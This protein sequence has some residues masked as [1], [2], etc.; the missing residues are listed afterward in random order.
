MQ[1]ISDAASRGHIQKWWKEQIVYQIYPRSFKDSNGDGVGDLRGIIDKL[2][3]IKSLGVTSVWINPIYASPND[4]NGY[5]ISDYRAIMP[6]FGTMADFDELL[7]GLHARGIKFIMDLVVNHSSDEHEWFKQSRSSR[8]NPYRDYYHWWP[9]EKGKPNWRWSY[10]DERGDAWKYDEQTDSYYLHY[11]AVKQPDLNWENPKVRQE[12]YDIM[13]FWAQKGVDGFRLD[14]FQF[15][16]K[17]TDFPQLPDEYMEGK[18]HI[19]KYHGMGPNIHAYLREMYEEVLS[20]YDVFAVSEGAGSS[21]QDAHDLVDTHRNELQIAY[22]FEGAELGKN[23][24]NPHTLL[25]FKQLY[26]AWDESFSSDGWLSIFLANHDMSRMVS[27]WGNDSDEHREASTK[28]LNT[29]LLTMRGTPFTYFGDELGMTNIRFQTIEEYKDID[30]INGYKKAQADGAD[31]DTFMRNLIEYSR[32]N[33]RTPMHW[34]ASTQAGFTTGEPWINVHENHAV[35]NVE[36]QEADPLSPLNH[37][38]ALTALRQQHK[39]LV[40][41]DYELLLAEHEDIYAY[42]RRYEGQSMLV[43]MNFSANTHTVSLAELLA[44]TQVL[45]NNTT[46]CVIEGEQITLTPYQAVV[47]G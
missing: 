38:R 31:M 27:R 13:H 28:L 24:D 30:A 17:D 9:A 47:L 42:V 36:A 25:E 26:S 3:Y 19:I 40:Y 14:A 23:V 33:S 39:V 16:S 34:D 15:V 32:D 5:D 1:V 35:I 8:D 6:E 7:E 43:L 22:H 45:V 11:F 37:F 29:F 2:D 20:Q 44:H 18:Q 41:G 10:F 21:F 12:V 4:D 46:D